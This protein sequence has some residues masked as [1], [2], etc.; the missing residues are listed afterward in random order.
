MGSLTVFSLSL[1]LSF[2][3]LFES[4][5]A[6]GV[7]Q[8]TK[9]DQSPAILVMPGGTSNLTYK[10]DNEKT[11]ALIE[12]YVSIVDKERL[13]CLEFVI[14]FQKQKLAEMNKTLA[15]F[16]IAQNQGMSEEDAKKWARDIIEKA[17][18][19]KK[20]RETN[21][22][23]V[24]KHNEELSKDFMAKAYKAF[25]FVFETVDSKLLALKELRPEAIS[26][27]DDKFLLFSEEASQTKPYTARSFVF[28]KGNGIAIVVTPG[29]LKQ[30][31][32]Q[33]YPHL[34]FVSYAGNSMTHSFKVKPGY[35]GMKILIDGG[36]NFKKKITVSDVEYSVTGADILTDEFKERLNNSFAE[37]IKLAF[38]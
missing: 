28:A 14:A 34:D 16:L 18:A 33:T 37:F 27:R 10:T 36:L 8:E 12:K 2:C 20:E 5:A 13:K 21:D 35:S 17:P 4:Y 6:E 1:F 31:F 25:F 30:S 38:P 15:E 23:L 24:G 11:N 32:I 7:T 22:A 29:K 9:G 3:I 19:F 26:V